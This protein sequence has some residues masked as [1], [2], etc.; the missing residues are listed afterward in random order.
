[1]LGHSASAVIKNTWFTLG[2]MNFMARRLLYR[3][4]SG[5][6]S[7][8][9]HESQPL[10]VCLTTTRERVFWLEFT[11]IFALDLQCLPRKKTPDLSGC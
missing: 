2:F 7:Y 9:F 5:Q 6:A 8:Q 10:Q 1:M 11:E 3:E 4:H